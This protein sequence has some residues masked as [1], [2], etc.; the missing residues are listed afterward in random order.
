MDL[1]GIAVLKYEVIDQ[2]FRESR[3]SGH[4]GHTHLIQHPSVLKI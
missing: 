2:H 1:H 3:N 4:T